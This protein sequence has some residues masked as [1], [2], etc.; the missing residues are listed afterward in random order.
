[1]NFEI[2]IYSQ[3]YYDELLRMMLKLYEDSIQQQ[4]MSL[5][6]IQKTL[7]TIPTHPQL[8]KILLFKQQTTIIGYTLLI[9]YWSNEYG[10]NILYID[11]LFVK[12]SYRSKGIGT[13]FF[14][15]LEKH[16]D[17]DTVALCLETTP[18]NKKAQL[19]Y[20]KNNFSIYENIFYFKELN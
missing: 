14:K 2:I 7:N 6:K 15:H 1:M 19:F 13:L 12:E 9:N 5:D 20:E 17:N 18:Q 4:S 3:T 16:V 10:G 11:E 8:G